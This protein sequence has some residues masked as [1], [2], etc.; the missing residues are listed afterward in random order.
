MNYDTID[1]VIKVLDKNFFWPERYH[2]VRLIVISDL[3]ELGWKCFKLFKHAGFKVC[4]I[5]EKWEWFGF[6]SGKGLL[7]YPDYEKLYIY[8]EGTEPIREEIEYGKSFY[9]SVFGCFFFLRSIA[10]ENA[11]SVF[12]DEMRKLKQKGIETY[13]CSI[14]SFSEINYKT[15]DE[16]LS[17]ASALDLRRYIDYNFDYT[18]TQ[19]ECLYRIYGIENV[20]ILKNYQED[21][22]NVVPLGELQG[23]SMKNV[24]YNKRIYLIGP[25][26]VGG[27]GCLA[28]NALY[29]Y[30]Q[31]CVEKFRYQVVS[32]TSANVRADLYQCISSIPIREH[33]IVL[34]INIS[35]WFDQNADRNNIL[36]LKS[37]YDNENRKNLF[38]NQPIHTNALANRLI[39]DEIMK[40]YLIQKIN[41]L[42]NKKNNRYIQKGE[43]LNQNAICTINEYV[44]RIHLADGDKRAGAIVMNGNPFTLGHRYLIEYAAKSMDKVYVF[45]V[46]EDRSFF[47][48]KDRF[49]MIRK[50]TGDI[51]N[52]IVVPSSEWVISYKTIPIYFEKEVKQEMKVDAQYDLEIFGRYIAPKLGIQKRFVGDEPIDKVTRQYNEQMKE[53][54]S[55]F[56][57]EVEIIPR[58]ESCGEII[59][60][61]GVRKYIEEGNWER[62]KRVVPDVT[63]E[64]CRKYASRK[65]E[66]I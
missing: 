38:C 26:I 3:N 29:G 31:K 27:Y 32:V 53:V 33:D 49:E 52:V 62:L 5:G 14:P 37:I 21:N 42:S 10:F 12:R 51:E 6:Q 39:A 60:A 8:S 65:N 17:E 25:C 59:S 22:T 43:L 34:G 7:D 4:V 41:E 15:E 19:L 56:G 1:M 58:L 55:L 28:D 46:Q 47:K 64:V 54:L 23:I 40:R 36:N 16:K 20:K 9:K 57:L 48:F 13:E 2:K 11:R 44:S 18:S 24:R 45:V 35:S 66:N 50:G 61:S 63:Y 30:L